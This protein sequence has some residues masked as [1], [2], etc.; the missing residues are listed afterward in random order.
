MARRCL[1]GEYTRRVRTVIP[2]HN[3]RHER[4]GRSHSAASVCLPCRC[5]EGSL[6]GE[7]LCRPDPCYGQPCKHNASCR[8]EQARFLSMTNHKKCPANGK[9]KWGISG[10]VC[11]RLHRHRLRG[12][13]MRDGR[14]RVRAGA[15]PERRNLYQ[16]P[17]LVRVS[18]PQRIQRSRRLRSPVC[19]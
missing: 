12:P 4:V 6:D 10:R 17:W 11:L 15:L 16:H 13:A 8:I 14:E 19:R 2:G 7:R 18:L 3:G 5:V 9:L 1:L